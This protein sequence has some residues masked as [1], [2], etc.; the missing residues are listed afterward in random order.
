MRR[1]CL[2]AANALAL[3]VGA[4]AALAQ[5]GPELLYTWTYMDWAFDDPAAEAAFDEA[6]VFERA[7]LAGVEADAAGNV[8]VTTPRWLDAAVPSTLSRV[9]VIDGKPL[10]VPFP[11]AAAHDLANPDAFRNAL[12]VFVDGK[13]R[14][15]VVDMGWVAGEDATPAGAQKLIG[16]D[17]ATGEEFIRF[18]IPDEVADSATSFLNDI[19]V[20]DVDEVIYITDSGNRGGSPVPAG[21]I[22]YDIATNTARRVLSNDP[23]VQD[24]PDLWLKVDGE[25]VFSGSRLAVGINGITLSPDRQTVYWSVTTGDAIYSAPAAMLR[26]A[27]ATP[28]EVSAAVSAPMRVGGGSDG[29]ATDPSGRL[30][31]TNLTLSR[32]EVLEAGATDTRVLFEGPDFIWPDSLAND[33]DGGMLLS[34]N[35]LNHAFGGVM[36]YDGD[37]PNFRV[38]RIPA[39]LAPSR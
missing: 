33:F 4:G 9:E 10:L 3:F 12:G 28:E 31:I 8:Y 24:D 35:H 32:V 15:W 18:P 19:V 34:T 16:I 37:A 36:R 26:D 27:S 7:P 22:V 21:I 30:W 6:R 25:E 11:S 29:I 20:D 1:S 17:L 2:G 5:E 13:N 38:W 14:M 23:T 39:D